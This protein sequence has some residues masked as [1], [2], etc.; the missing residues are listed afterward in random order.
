MPA[1][2]QKPA[3]KADTAGSR[4]LRTRRRTDPRQ[5][6]TNLQHAAPL[7]RQNTATFRADD[8]V[9]RSLSQSTA[10]YFFT[11]L[12]S[13]IFDADTYYLIAHGIG[14]IPTAK[15]A[16]WDDIAND[17]NRFSRRIYC[18]DYFSELDL[19][20]ETDK[21]P[22]KFRIPNPN[23]HP[24]TSGGDYQATQGVEEYVAHTRVEVKKLQ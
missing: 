15:P 22:A 6:S 13:V 9:S 21:P 5:R 16:T 19:T 20:A 17:W 3:K 2:Q 18:Q 8:D 12:S 1:A 14:F 7:A 4:V 24:K 11:N 10:K 23:W